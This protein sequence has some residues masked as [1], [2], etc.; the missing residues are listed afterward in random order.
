MLDREIKTFPQI[1]F[2]DGSLSGGIGGGRAQIQG[3]DSLQEAKEI[4]LV[5]QTGALPVKFDTLDRTDISATLGKD[6]LSEAWRR[7]SRGLILVAFFL[8]L[9]YRFLGSSRLPGSR[10]TRRSCTRRSSSST[11]R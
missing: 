7:R 10:S 2:T 9:F 1:D 8:L 3:L 5:L 11:S 6:S 4:A